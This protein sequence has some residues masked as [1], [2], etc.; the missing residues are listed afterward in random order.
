MLG[1]EFP[2]FGP[3]KDPSGVGH[4]SDDGKQFIV[5]FPEGLALSEYYINQIALATI[6]FTKDGTGRG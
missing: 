5:D 2:V 1:R 6:S 3:D 4:I